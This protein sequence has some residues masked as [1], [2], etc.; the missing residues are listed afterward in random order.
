LVSEERE[1]EMLK[2]Y[3][4]QKKKKPSSQVN[5]FWVY[6]TIKEEVLAMFFKVL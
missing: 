6:K 3:K 5:F 2:L 1:K 4:S